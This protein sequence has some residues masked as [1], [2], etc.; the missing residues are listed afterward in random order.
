MQTRDY[1]QHSLVALVPLK[2]IQLI[3]VEDLSLLSY[4]MLMIIF[5]FI[6]QLREALFYPEK[7]DINVSIILYVEYALN[8][9]VFFSSRNKSTSEDTCKKIVNQ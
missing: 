4:L 3:S 8:S 2:D 6:F 7:I 1:S 5:F 9:G